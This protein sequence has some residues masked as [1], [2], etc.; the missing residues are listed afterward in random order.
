MCPKKLSAFI[1]HVT[2][3]TKQPIINNP[4]RQDVAEFVQDTNRMAW[5]CF[6]HSFAKFEGTKRV[7]FHVFFILCKLCSLLNFT[8]TLIRTFL[9]STNHLEVQTTEGWTIEHPLYIVI[10]IN[11]SYSPREKVLF[12][13]FHH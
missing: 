8:K 10:S 7:L 6:R 3:G 1:I 2:T 5:V 13:V 11:F 12:S 9:V 4:H